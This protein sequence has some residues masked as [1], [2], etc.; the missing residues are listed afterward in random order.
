MDS[1][2]TRPGHPQNVSKTI[3]FAAFIE[4]FFARVCKFANFE[5]PKIHQS[6]LRMLDFSRPHVYGRPV[7]RMTPHRKPSILPRRFY[8]FWNTEYVSKPLRM[9]HFDLRY[10]CSSGRLLF[11]VR[12]LRPVVL[13]L[14]HFSSFWLHFAEPRA[15]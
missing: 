9:H 14:Y 2:A 7:D 1:G 6:P 3:D 15:P 10:A 5:T 4:R 11:C 12:L 8:V 13:V